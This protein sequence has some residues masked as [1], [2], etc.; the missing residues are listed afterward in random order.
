[1]GRRTDKTGRGR[2]MGAETSPTCLVIQGAW[3]GDKRD[4]SSD[5][6]STRDGQAALGVRGTGH[7]GLASGPP[8]GINPAD[9][10]M[11]DFQPPELGGNQY[12]CSRHLRC[13]TLF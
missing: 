7:A 8:E 3:G 2:W 9:A 5:P 10:L 12:Y 6:G 1:M 13:G 11:S 4:A